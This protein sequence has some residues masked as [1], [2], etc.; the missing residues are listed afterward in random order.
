MSFPIPVSKARLGRFVLS[1]FACVIIPTFLLSADATAEAARKIAKEW[2]DVV[3]TVRMVIKERSVTMGQESP[4]SE[5]VTEALAT[6]IDKSGLAVLSLYSTDPTELLKHMSFG[7]EYESDYA[8]ESEVKDLKMLMPDGKEIKANIILRDEDLGLVF[9]C[10]VEKYDQPFT[11]LD[12]GSS[13][14]PILFDQ[15]VILSRLGVAAGYAPS[16]LLNRIQAVITNPRTY[17]VPEA[18]A[19]ESGLGT[20]A[21]ALNKKV[22]GIVLLRALKSGVV[23]LSQVLSGPTGGVVEIV[24]L[25]AETI[26]DVAKQAL[27]IIRKEGTE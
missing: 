4:G 7:G 11:A 8:W 1:I 15:I 2:Q 16:A 23:S 13:S 10:P 18:S 26:K 25:P 21:F 6:I 9:I 22:I 27:A 12:L 24:I 20:P 14:E 5:F 17:F 3:V 19:L